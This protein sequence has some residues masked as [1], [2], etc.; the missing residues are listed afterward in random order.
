MCQEVLRYRTNLHILLVTWLVHKVDC[1]Y[2]ICTFIS[3]CALADEINSDNTSTIIIVVGTLLGL[4][5]FI[6]IV[7]ILV[8]FTIKCIERGK[9]KKLEV[10]AENTAKQERA[11]SPEYEEINERVYTEINIKRNEAYIGFSKN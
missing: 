5:S 11:Q 4:L 2:F 6:F 1:I 8:A 3:Q 10:K 7:I 9:R